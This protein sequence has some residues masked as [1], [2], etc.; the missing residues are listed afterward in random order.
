MFFPTLSFFKI[1]KYIDDITNTYLKIQ[2]DRETKQ[3]VYKLIKSPP[4]NNDD[5]SKYKTWMETIFVMKI[6]W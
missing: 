2:K 4:N 5:Y 1:N 3:F 6:I